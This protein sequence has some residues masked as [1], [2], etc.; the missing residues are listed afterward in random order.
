MKTTVNRLLAPDFLLYIP[1][2]ISGISCLVGMHL[3][4][5]LKMP[6]SFTRMPALV[7]FL[8]MQR[9]SG[10]QIS[11]SQATCLVLIAWFA[12]GTAA[13]V[14]REESSAPRTTLSEFEKLLHSTAIIAVDVRSAESYRQGHI[15]GALSIPID[16]IAAHAEE[17]KKIGKPIVAYCS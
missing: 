9:C 12:L 3:E 16:S 8:R 10:G 11:K 6:D 17:L 13:A 2:H 1:L 15:P 14:Q 7:E 5:R 4:R